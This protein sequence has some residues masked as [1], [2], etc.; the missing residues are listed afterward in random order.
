[1]TS[2]LWHMA[3]DGRFGEARAGTAPSTRE[4][5]QPTS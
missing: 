3:T 4:P 1:M 2:K 5:S